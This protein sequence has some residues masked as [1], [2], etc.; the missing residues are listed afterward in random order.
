MPRY[1]FNIRSPDIYLAD[2]QGIVLRDIDHVWE[3]AIKGARGILAAHLRA[4][5]P[6]DHQKFEVTD[7]DN[8]VVFVLR[9][10]DVINLPDPPD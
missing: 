1:F 7:E 3:E 2:E 10:R 5:R 4:G 8:D 9:F 6:V